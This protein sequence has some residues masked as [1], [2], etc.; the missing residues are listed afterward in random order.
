MRA[1]C[2][3]VKET[4]DFSILEHPTPFD[5]APGTEVPLLEHVRHSVNYTLN[6]LG[7]HKLSL[8]G[9]A[10][11]NDCLNLNCFS[12]EPGESFQLF[13]PSKGPIAESVFIAGMFVK[14][15]EE[16]AALCDQL[17]LAEE[18]KTIHRAVSDME[19]AVLRYGWDG[20]WF[21]RAYDASGNKVGSH[22]CKEGQIFIEPQGFCTMAGI[23][24]KSGEGLKAME[25]VRARL[26]GEYAWSCWIPAIPSIT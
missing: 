18:S 24:K 4:G 13:G 16:Y 17:D 14:Y 8:I 7:P 3:Y 26:L 12:E 1:V 21:L 2:T 15:G 9:R 10:D 5:N 23:S 19:T 20:E 22:E 6:N 11:W 25:S